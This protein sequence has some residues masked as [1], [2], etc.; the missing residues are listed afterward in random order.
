MINIIVQLQSLHYILWICAEEI[1][2]SGTGSN[3]WRPV[4]SYILMSVLYALNA[5]AWVV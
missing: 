3:G 1:P 2:Q 5:Q 4:K